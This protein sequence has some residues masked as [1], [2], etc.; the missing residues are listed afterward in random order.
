MLDIGCATGQLLQEV[1]RIY[2]N[3]KL[4]G[5]DK[6]KEMLQVAKAKNMDITFE[7]INAEELNFS[8]KFNVIT[9]CHSFPYYN[10]KHKVMESVENMLSDD[11][12]AIFVQA[13]I[14][15][16][17]DR[18]VMA[19]IERTAESAQYLS[20]KDFL[21]IANDYFD[22]EDVFLIKERAFMPSIY[23]FVLRKKYEYTTH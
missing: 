3:V 8:E 21:K 12:I 5:V 7:C 23:G 22:T 9:C 2:P 15:N 14:N 10:D 1:R 11:G 20:K 18:I 4:T 19:I 17:Y 13:S 6:S 16:W